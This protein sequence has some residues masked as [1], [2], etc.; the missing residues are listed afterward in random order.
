MITGRPMFPGSTVEEQLQL[1]FRT[2]G[3]PTEESWPGSES[4]QQLQAYNFPHWL[5]MDLKSV[6]PRLSPT[7]QDLMRQLLQYQANR[8]ISAEKAKLH[9]YFM[10]FMPAIL[11]DLPDTSSIFEIPGVCLYTNPV[12]HCRAPA[13]CSGA[14]LPVFGVCR[15]HHLRAG[16]A[17][18]GPAR[19]ILRAPKLLFPQSP[20]WLIYNNCLSFLL[21]CL[22]KPRQAP[23]VHAVLMRP[24]GWISDF[25]RFT[26]GN[27]IARF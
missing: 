15:L 24:G 8:R 27:L 19:T 21:C 13:G 17:A 26:F 11:N 3:S 1:I 16:H 22:L 5:G 20:H 12:P 23:P 25:P 2:L 10:Q 6:A 18:G 4:N 9:L 14:V 7:G